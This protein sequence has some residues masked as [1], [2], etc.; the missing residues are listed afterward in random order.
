MDLRFRAA[1]RVLE[2]VCGIG[3][4]LQRMQ[5]IGW[6]VEGVEMDGNAA[7]VPRTALSDPVHVAGFRRAGLEAARF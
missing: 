7:E 2:V 6:Q 5:S 1:C 4:F 3:G